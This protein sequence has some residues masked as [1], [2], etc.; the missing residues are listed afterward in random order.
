MQN[1]TIVEEN[2]ANLPSDLATPLLRSY[3]KHV[4]QNECMRLFIAAIPMIAM[5]VKEFS[6]PSMGV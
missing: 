6:F 2:L 3:T 1:I 4:V 5:D